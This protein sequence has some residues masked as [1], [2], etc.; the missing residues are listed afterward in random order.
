MKPTVIKLVLIT[1]ASLMLV[2]AY[3]FDLHT[4]LT[5]NNLQSIS[6]SLRDFVDANPK[7]SFFIAF[8]IMFFVYSL[9]LPAAALMSLTAGYVFN[10][11]TGLL[12]VLTSSLMAAT[13]TFLISRYIARDWLAEKFARY[14][15]VVDREIEA[16]GLLY[17][18]GI[19]M[20]PGIPFI[21]LNSTFGITKLPLTAFCLST[22]L[23]MIP[24]SSILV[25][26]GK[27]LNSI[28]SMGDILTPKLILSLLL[29]AS[30]PII[31]RII[32]SF[33]VK[34]AS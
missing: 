32:K 11:S 26:A 15:D 17:A 13:I 12:L 7:A 16:H 10:F 30:F 33:V 25:N 34:K 14:M 24:I 5:L 19:R 28:Q 31:V 27:Q 1:L 3:I 8:G 22:F 6:V 9:P 21:A 4:L 2:L 23:G 20:V 29:L 18:L